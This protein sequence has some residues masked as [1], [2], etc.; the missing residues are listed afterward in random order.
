MLTIQEQNTWR[1]THLGKFNGIPGTGKRIEIQGIVTWR[2]VNGLITERR[3]VIDT[4][5]LLQQPG[6]IPPIGETSG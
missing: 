2:I 4:L 3:A 6:V 5:G 1:G